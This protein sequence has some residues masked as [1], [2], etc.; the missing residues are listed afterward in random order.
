[1]QIDKLIYINYMFLAG[2]KL[3][4]IGGMPM[5]IRCCYLGFYVTV[6]TTFGADDWCTE[7][8]RILD[9]WMREGR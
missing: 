1:M 4:A 9:N 2:E 7:L 8:P 6:M 3:Q 5:P